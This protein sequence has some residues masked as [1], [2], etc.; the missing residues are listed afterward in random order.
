MLG[1]QLQQAALGLPYRL[2]GGP[3]PEEDPGSRGTESNSG[4]E[5][6]PEVVEEAAPPRPPP[7]PPPHTTILALL[8]TPPGDS[9]VWPRKG[10]GGG[11]GRGERW[12]LRSLGPEGTGSG[13]PGIVSSSHSPASA[14]EEVLPGALRWCLPRCIVEQ[15][16]GLRGSWAVEEGART[17]KPR[18]LPG[19]SGGEASERTPRGAGAG[20]GGGR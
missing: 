13:T 7:K 8:L 17:P 4:R 1:V 2:E 14:R 10:G 20:P 3:L 5:I 16:T 12:R 9:Q 18:A 15:E 11:G 6:W 19:T